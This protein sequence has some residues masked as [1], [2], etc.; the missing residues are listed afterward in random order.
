M[1]LPSEIYTKL[2]SY[3]WHATTIRDV[4]QSRAGRPQHGR[5]YIGQT[6]LSKKQ[7]LTILASAV[8]YRP[9]SEIG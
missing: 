4:T 6:T 1:K 5:K 2:L 3:G 9:Q 7:Y 8:Q